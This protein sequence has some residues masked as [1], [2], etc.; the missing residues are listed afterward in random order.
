M[1]RRALHVA[2]ILWPAFV[3]AGVLEMLV[4]SVLDPSLVRIGPWEPEA[5]TVY[6]LGFLVFWAVLSLSGA[7]SHLMMRG[8]AHGARLGGSP[9]S[10]PTPRVRRPAA[11]PVAPAVTS[12]LRCGAE[13]PLSSGR[14]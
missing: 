8:D 1:S 12:R 3:M 14:C 11:A 2:Q 13:A 5:R 7:L 4:F 9:P 6:S 10:P